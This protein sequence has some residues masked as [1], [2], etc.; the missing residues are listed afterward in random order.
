MTETMQYARKVGGSL[1]V[2]IPKEIAELENIH[3][4]EMIQIEIHKIKKDWFGC[5][6]GVGGPLQKDEKVDIHE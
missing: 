2:T 4:G 3:P 1:M 6:K 5:L